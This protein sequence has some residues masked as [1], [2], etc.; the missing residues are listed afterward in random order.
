MGGQD[1]DDRDTDRERRDGTKP[2]NSA[3][4]AVKDPNEKTDGKPGA[5]AQGDETDPGAG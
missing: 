3:P 1:R 5:P 4:D 2:A